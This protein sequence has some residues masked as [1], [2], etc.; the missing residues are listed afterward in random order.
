MVAAAA[1]TSQESI[2]MR[3]IVTGSKGQLG[4]EIIPRLDAAGHH[5]VLGLDL[6]NC[7]RTNRGAV[8]GASGEFAPEAGTTGAALTAVEVS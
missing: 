6:H 4:N 2:T 1:L 7:D 3:I 8:L 5:E